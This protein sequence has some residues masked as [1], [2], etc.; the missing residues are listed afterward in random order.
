MRIVG[1]KRAVGSSRQ[2][3]RCGRHSIPFS[4][5]WTTDF[6]LQSVGKKHRHCTGSGLRVV[7]LRLSY[8]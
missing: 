5:N 7:S 8:N 4:K 1:P 2:W 6:L 3:E